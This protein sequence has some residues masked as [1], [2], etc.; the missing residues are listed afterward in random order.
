MQRHISDLEARFGVEFANFLTAI[1][2]L[3]FSVR[4]VIEEMRTA[5][6]KDYFGAAT[7]ATAAQTAAALV[8]AALALQDSLT[9]AIE[10][11]DAYEP[12]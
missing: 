7:L 8:P 11:L 4:T 6:R 2:D 10:K 9:A 12:A 1:V 3:K 5:L